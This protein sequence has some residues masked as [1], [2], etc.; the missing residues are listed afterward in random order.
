M[1]GSRALQQNDDALLKAMIP[2]L[3]SLYAGYAAA[4][5]NE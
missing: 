1:A 4:N 3:D 2:V 5:R